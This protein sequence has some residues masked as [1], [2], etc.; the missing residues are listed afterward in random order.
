[1]GIL[2]MKGKIVKKELNK[3]AKEASLL[4]E[5]IKLSLAESG[6]QS[7]AELRKTSKRQKNI[8]KREL[9]QAKLQSKEYVSNNP[10]VVV[11]LVAATAI[12]TAS[13][14]LSSFALVQIL[15]ASRR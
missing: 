12:I 1:M 2:N 3:A 7:V 13:T 4:S 10:D 6:K 11:V 5:E 15:K 8:A 9:K 14:I